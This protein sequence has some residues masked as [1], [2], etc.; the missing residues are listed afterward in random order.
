MALTRKML[1]AMELDEDKVSQIIDAH[2]AVID[3]IAKERDTFK[4]DAEKYKAEAERLGSVEKDL[5]KAQA[6]LEDAEKTAEK[7]KALQSEYDEYKAD[8]DAKATQSA[9][10]KAY[11]ELLKQAGVS[12]KRFDAI[13]KVS[14]MSKVELDKDG[15]VKDSKAVVDSIKSEWAD[16]VVTEGKQGAKTPTPPAATPTKAFTRD[17]IKG[18]SPDEINKNW[19]DIKTSLN[20]NSL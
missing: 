6:Q 9:K 3:E 20:N 18:M 15:K 7:L 10:E 4:A 13:I 12:D 14:D 11:R 5:V 1:K 17:D 8:V 16:F 2:Q 19:D